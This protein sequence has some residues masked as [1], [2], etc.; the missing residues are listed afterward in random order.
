MLH[1][2]NWGDASM[3]F[4]TAL[5]SDPRKGS[6]YEA[7]KHGLIKANAVRATSKGLQF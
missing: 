5:D 3:I 7:L 2:K 6:G 1:K 4:R